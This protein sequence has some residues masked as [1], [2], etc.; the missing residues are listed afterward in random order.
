[1]L[2]KGRGLMI[3][4][5]IKAPFPKSAMT[6]THLILTCV[7][8]LTRKGLHILIML[9]RVQTIRGEKYG[10]EACDAIIC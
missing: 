3:K 5:T 1:M 4:Y 7:C 9:F 8:E 6:L 2:A 10:R